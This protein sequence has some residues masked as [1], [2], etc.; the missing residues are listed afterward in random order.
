MMVKADA[1][2]L[3]V[4]SCPGDN[5]EHVMRMLTDG[6]GDLLAGVPDGERDDRRYWVNFLAYRV[7]SEHPDLETTKRPREIPGKEHWVPSGYDDFWQ[8]QARTGV[9][10]IEFSGLGYARH[11]KASYE[12]FCQLRTEGVIPKGVPFQVCLPLTESATRIFMRDERTF[13]LVRQGYEDALRREIDEICRAIPA[14]DLLIQWD[15]CIEV[16][17]VATGDQD[18]VMLTWESSSDPFNRYIEAL[19][20]LSPEIPQS[21]PVGLHLCYGDLYKRHL[22]EPT[23]LAVVV[24]M[25]NA[26]AAATGHRVSYLHF[27]VPADRDDDAYFTPL[28]DLSIGNTMVYAGLVHDDTGVAGSVR[29]LEVLRQY[30]EGPLGIATECGFGGRDVDSVPN[31]L[32]IHREVVNH[33]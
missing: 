12:L 13:N 21:V 11:A 33:I 32:N 24:R 14:E 27:P 3:V 30:Y 23:D 28:R 17:A 20:T 1:P 29:R 2:V 10:K 9:T 4:G 26:G 7:Y 25:A 16:L 22:V 5:A 18:G 15:I 19:E 6:I 8:F 31:L